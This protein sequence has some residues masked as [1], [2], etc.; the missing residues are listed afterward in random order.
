MSAKTILITGGLG[1]IGSALIRRMLSTTDHIIVNV[2]FQGYSSDFRNIDKLIALNKAYSER[3]L[4]FNVD[5]SEKF[6]LEKV[7]LKVKP[8]L[9]FHLAAESHV[10][11][12]IDDPLPFIKSNVIGT[13]NLLE[14]TRSFYKKLNID[15]KK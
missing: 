3:Y 13:F 14:V 2:D 12:S 7:F 10:D 6:K 11:R 1:F 8:D 5:L 4:F 15:K 9:V